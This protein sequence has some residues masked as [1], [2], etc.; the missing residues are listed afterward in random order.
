MSFIFSTL[1]SE[2]VKPFDRM[3]EV[4]T[5]STTRTIT[6]TTTTISYAAFRRDCVV[7]KGTGKNE[8]SLSEWYRYLAT[9]T[10]VGTS[11][12]SPPCFS[13]EQES[14]YD[15]LKSREKDVERREAQLEC[16]KT[17]LRKRTIRQALNIEKEEKKVRLRQHEKHERVKALIMKVKD[18]RKIIER[19]RAILSRE[20]EQRP[21]ARDEPCMICTVAAKNAVFSPCGH[22]TCADCAFRWIHIEEKHKCPFCNQKAE[23]MELLNP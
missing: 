5:T 7:P 4:I 8:W 3:S 17:E 6:S 14:T 15:Q 12:P 2:V 22:L 20:R 11:P 18:D 16:A 23:F 21:E 9:H 10:S 19:E 13:S 1:F